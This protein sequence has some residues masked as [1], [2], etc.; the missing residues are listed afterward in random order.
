MYRDW[1]KQLEIINAIREFN[2]PLHDIC[3]KRKISYPTYYYWVNKV[4]RKKKA[5]RH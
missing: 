1:E 3:D 4:K 2:I 5:R